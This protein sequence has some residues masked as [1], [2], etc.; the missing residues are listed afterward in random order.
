[1]NHRSSPPYPKGFV[2]I[3]VLMY[4][5]IIALIL[6]ASAALVSFTNRARAKQLVEREVEEQGRQVLEQILYTVRNASEI[7]SPTNGATGTSLS[8]TVEDA[9]ASPTVFALSGN[10]FT[11]S[12]GTATAVSLTNSNVLATAFSVENLSRADTPGTVRVSFTLSGTVTS[13][14][15]PFLYSQTFYGAASLR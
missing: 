8:V 3:E 12:E 11:I 7:V 14:S 6:A 13:G 9:S 5:G 10:T 1:M 15:T 2:L 4:I